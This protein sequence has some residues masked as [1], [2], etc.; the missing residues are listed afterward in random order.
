LDEQSEKQLVAECLGGDRD[1][2]ATLV[3]RHSRAIFALCL[4]M[5]REVHDAEDVAQETLVRG[6]REL[7]QLR[8]GAQFRRWLLKIARNLCLD[9]IRAQKRGRQMLEKRSNPRTVVPYDYMDLHDAVTR[10]PEKYRLPLVLYY[11]DG[12]SSESVAR[13]LDLTPAGV[14]TRLSRARRA[15]RALL[16]SKEVSD[17]R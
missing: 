3:K 2:Y 8:D 6:F 9:F 17:G 12:Q 11:F 7:D 14:L 16:A 5:L 13:A 4:A 10:L 15:L 1:A